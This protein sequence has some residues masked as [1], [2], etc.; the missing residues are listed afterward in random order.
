[1]SAKS[2][3][4]DLTN[5]FSGELQVTL[6]KLNLKIRLPV[7]IDDG[8]TFAFFLQFFQSHFL[9]STSEFGDAP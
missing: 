3:P 5:P 6:S 4:V 7:L 2:Y 8:V 9:Y 1:M